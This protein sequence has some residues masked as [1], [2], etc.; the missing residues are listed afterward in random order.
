MVAIW[1]LCLDF[2]G[3]GCVG[4]RVAVGL[5][6]VPS[7]GPRSRGR[8]NCIHL[9]GVPSFCPV[10]PALIE[11]LWLLELCLLLPTWPDADATT[12]EEDIGVYYQL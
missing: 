4:S 3:G 8:A 11:A 10:D 9:W 2:S 1:H 5:L 12:S 6:G 7:T